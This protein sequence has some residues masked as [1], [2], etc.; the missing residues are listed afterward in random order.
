MGSVMWEHF[1]EYFGNGLLIFAGIT[2]FIVFLLIVLYG[3][4][5][6]IENNEWVLWFELIIVGPGLVTLGVERLIKDVRKK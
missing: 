2:T 5:R 1:K 4:A 3:E 6:I